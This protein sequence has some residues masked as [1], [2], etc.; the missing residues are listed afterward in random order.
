MTE[1][2]SPNQTGYFQ[3][4]IDLVQ[5]KDL[6]EAFTAQQTA[7]E[8]FLQSIT[9]TRSQH[10]YAPDKWSVKEVL[11]HISD[12]ERIFSYRALCIA[13]GEKQA[14]SGFNENEYAAVSDANRNSWAFLM[15]EFM[16]VRKASWCLFKGFDACMLAREGTANGQLMKV[17]SLGFILL[18]HYYHHEKVLKMNY[19]IV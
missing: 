14:L 13:R 16:A 11:Q 2:S 5:E 4:Y 17:E 10:R 15:E 18:G 6:L 1:P 8:V 3:R 9:E 7:L 12:C 19:R